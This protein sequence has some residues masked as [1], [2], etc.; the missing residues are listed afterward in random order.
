MSK[1]VI[2]LAAKDLVEVFNNL[3]LSKDFLENADFSMEIDIKDSKENFEYFCKSRKIK[4]WNFLNIQEPE[5]EKKNEET[6]ETTTNP[7]YEG[8][9]DIFRLLTKDQEFSINPYNLILKVVKIVEKIKKKSPALRFTKSIF[10]PYLDS[11]NS[12][13][14]ENSKED[15]I[16]TKLIQYYYKGVSR[17]EM[18]DHVLRS[19]KSNW[20]KLEKCEG[21]SNIISL[22]MN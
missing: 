12:L 2:K 22:I 16:F 17:E 4:E 1:V 3:E 5:P 11:L 15:E 14:V 8:F 13:I 18:L 10:D 20:K 19:L 9:Y 7:D 21:V 6:S